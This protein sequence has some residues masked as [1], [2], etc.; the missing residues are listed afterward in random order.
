MDFPYIMQSQDQLF[1][2]HLPK[3]GGTTLIS[4][5]DD[6]FATSEICPEQIEEKFKLL[7]YTDLAGYRLIRG[8]FGYDLYKSLPKKPIYL[9]M[10]RDPILRVI[11]LY[12]F[13]KRNLNNDLISNGLED[14]RS[15]K[16]NSYLDLTHFVRSED[17]RLSVEN[18]QTRYILAN[19]YDPLEGLTDKEILEIAKKRISEEFLFFG[20]L[21]KYDESLQ[22]LTYTFGWPP[23]QSYQKKMVAPNINKIEGLPSEA[24]TAIREKNQLDIELYNYAS[25]LFYARYQ[26]MVQRLIKKSYIDNFSKWHMFEEN[27]DVSISMD[28]SICGMGW[29]PREL[30]SEGI[31]FRWMGLEKEASIDVGLSKNSDFTI[32]IHILDSIHFQCLQNFKFLIN[33]VVVPLRFLDGDEYQGIYQGVIKSQII[34]LNPTYTRLLFQVAKTFIPKDMDPNNFDNRRLSIALQKISIQKQTKE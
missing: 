29:Y 1:Y 30:N 15:I 33:G 11:S 16:S 4:L 20:L 8:H 24:I 12:E 7:S 31:A 13:S 18:N 19:P 26:T 14:E 28:Q 34:E 10:L 17:N 5:L 21:E 3:T 27:T 23:I 32:T 9:T 6:H 25:E 2:M 22:L